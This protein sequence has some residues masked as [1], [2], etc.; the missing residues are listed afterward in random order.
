MINWRKLALSF[1][2]LVAVG[3]VWGVLAVVIGG[4]PS[5]VAVPCGLLLGGITVVGL[6]FW[7][8]E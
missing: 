3:L 5:V 8:T 6:S 4:L 7:Y 1:A 2:A